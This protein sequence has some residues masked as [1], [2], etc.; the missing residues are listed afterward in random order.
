[1]CGALNLPEN[2]TQQEIPL[3]LSEFIDA[4]DPP[5]YFTFGSCTQ[6][7]L[8]GT[9]RLFVD[10]IKLLGKRSIVQSDWDNLSDV[11][12]DPN[13]YQAH[14][15]PHDRV[16]PHCSIVIHHGGAGTTQTT[17]IAGKPS[18]IVA[19]AFDQPYWGKKLQRLG[20]AGKLLHRRSVT[21]KI[22]AQGIRSV[23]NSPQ[24]KANAASL[25]QRME[26]ENGVK[27][28]VEMIQ[29]RFNKNG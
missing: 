18:V 13:I 1:V 7:D 23:L 25:G 11:N 10:A 14:K 6:F 3:A 27:S 29:K 21:P 9:T 26:A 5:L 12:E 17:L 24:M 16:F 15:I 8:E 22:L 28:A 19:H 2:G 4:G 20:C